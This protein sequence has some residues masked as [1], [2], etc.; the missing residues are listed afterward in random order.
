MTNELS[1]NKGLLSATDPDPIGMFNSTSGSPVMLLCEHAGRF[2]PKSLEALGLPKAVIDTHRGWD[3]GAKAL[4]T[5][6]SEKIC[7]PLI[8]QR[9]SRLVI[10]CNRPPESSESIPLQSDG[11]IIPGNKNLSDANILLRRKAIFDPMNTALDE[12]LS[13]TKKKAVFSIHSFTP[14]MNGKKRPWNAGFLSRLDIPT[15]TLLVAA[16]E[17]MAPDLNLALNKPYKIEPGSDWFIPAY[18]EP[19]KLAHTLIEVR[20]D[21]LQTLKNISRWADLISNAITQVV[22][23]L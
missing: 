19:R 16:I 21:Q 15:A 20:N 13:M 4:A 22:N 5:Q 11:V 23:R 14:K 8:V 9:Y 2:V 7:A 10:D 18:A 17:A 12:V 6:V 1:R 3:I